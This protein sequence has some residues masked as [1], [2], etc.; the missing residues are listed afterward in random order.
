MNRRLYPRIIEFNILDKC[1]YFYENASTSPSG[2]SPTGQGQM[3]PFPV[4][5]DAKAEEETGI[6]MH[7]GHV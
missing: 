3:A 2:T 1:F 4:G 6:S 5:G 7:H